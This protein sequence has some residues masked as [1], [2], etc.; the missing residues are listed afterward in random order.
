MIEATRMMLKSHSYFRTKML[1]LTEN[2]YKNYIFQ[3]VR[4]VASD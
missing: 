1:Y 2:K 4:I 3:K